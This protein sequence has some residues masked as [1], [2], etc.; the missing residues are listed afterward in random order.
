MDAQTPTRIAV[1][2]SGGDAPGMNPALRAAVRWAF[3]H[4]AEPWVVQEGYA[5]LIQGGD[6]IRPAQWSDTS[7]VLHRGG[8][9]LGTAR[10]KVFRQ[11]EGRRQA[12]RTLLL[13]GLS[14]LVVI[15]GDGSLTGA[16]LLRDEWAEHCRALLDAGEIEA[17][18]VA[19]HPELFIVGLVG[20][21]DNDLWGTDMT[22]GCDTALHRVVDAVD[23]LTSTAESHR[24]AFV[25]EVMGR[26]CGYLALAAAICCGADHV[27]LP[28]CPDPDWCTAL[29]ASVKRGRAAGSRKSVVLV[30]EGALDETGAPLTAAQVRQALEDAGYEARLTVLGHVQRGGRPSAYDRVM[31]SVLGARAAQTLLTLQP[32]EGPQLIATTGEGVFQRPLMPCIAHTHATNDALAEGRFSDAVTARGAVFSE[33]LGLLGELTQEPAPLPARP[34]RV[35]VVHVGAPAPGMN[36]VLRGLAR[37]AATRGL[38]L[39]GAQEGLRGL[40]DGLV[41]PLTAA[42]T[43]DLLGLGATALGTNRWAPATRE[44]RSTVL[45]ALERHDV[46]SVVLVGGFESL[47]VAELLGSSGRPVAVMPA[48]ISNNV[49]GTERSLG[50]DTALG[51]ILEAVDRLQTSAVGS[52]NRVFVVEVH[53]RR[54]G[55]LATAAGLGG[56]VNLVYTHENGIALGDLQADCARLNATFDHGS[57]VGTVLVADQASDALDATA[58]AGLLQAESGGRFDARV[59][60][61]GHLQQ[62]AVPSPRDRLAGMRLAAAALTH[63]VDGQDAVLLGLKRDTVVAVD[64][65]HALAGADLRNRRPLVPQHQV[66][67]EL[68]ARLSLRTSS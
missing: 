57:S 52:R 50:V 17:D 55:Y 46:D 24:R 47:G 21:I 13:A 30:A 10:S 39:L 37:L 45:L 6:A 9:L 59:C 25:V 67:G 19:A 65:D 68:N 49:P 5:G 36:A 48:T 1:M 20:S 11:P 63:A 61:L 27:F 3:A 7:F 16:N 66:L 26:R 33:L 41:E 32:G 54:C 29:M 34:R 14:R 28:E 15:G 4:G 44:E 22:I 18:T 62:G 31:S 53:G 23:T 58:L 51:S 56:G 43:R 12:V 42:G 2:T 40:V 8:T 64:I 38:V 35:L 60:V